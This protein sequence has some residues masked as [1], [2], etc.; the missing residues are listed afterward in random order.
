M[1]AG[2]AGKARRLVGNDR[3]NRVVVVHGPADPM[4]T[5]TLD[6]VGLDVVDEIG[7]VTVWAPRDLREPDWCSWELPS[8]EPDYPV[9]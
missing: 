9:G 5:Y 3:V 6:L 7:D 1:R 8:R 2:R 4:L